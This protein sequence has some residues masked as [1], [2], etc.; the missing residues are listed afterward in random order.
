MPFGCV[1][2]QLQTWQFFNSV[3][4]SPRAL[5]VT[6]RCIHFKAVFCVES[7]LLRQQSADEMTGVCVCVCLCAC[8]CVGTYVFVWASI[9]L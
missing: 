8:V 2:K 5:T 9:I 3:V 7:V 6:H 1:A 4:R